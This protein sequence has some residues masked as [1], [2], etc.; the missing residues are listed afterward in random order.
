MRRTNC[1]R[2]L[3]EQLSVRPPARGPSV[4][5]A[6]RT[7]VEEFIKVFQA[8]EDRSTAAEALGVAYGSVVSREKNLRTLGVNLKVMPRKQRSNGLDVAAL[9]DMIDGLQS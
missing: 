6:A 4:E 9:N 8:S 1:W 2:D 3:A 7:S 5:M